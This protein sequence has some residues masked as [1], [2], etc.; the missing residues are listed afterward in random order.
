MTATQDT[1]ATKAVK[2]GWRESQ[3]LSLDRIGW[4]IRSATQQG[5]SH[6]KVMWFDIFFIAEP[7][8]IRELI[9]K[10]PHLLHRDPFTTNVLRRIMG[11][12]V[13]IAED[14]AW[15]RQRK[16]VAPAFHAMRIRA[17]AE[18]MAAYTREMVGRWQDGQTVALDKE[19]TQLTLRI[20]AKTMFNVDLL[21][22]A[23]RIG[24]LMQDLLETGEKQ[25]DAAYP[26]PNWVPT[27]T[28]RRQNAALRELHELIRDIIRQRQA[29]GGDAG[30]LLSMLLAARDDEGRPMSEAQII[31]ECVTLLAA[32]HETTAVALM[33]AW[34]LLAQH[35]DVARRLE[36]EVDD[37]LAGQPVTFERLAELPY[38]ES[39][40]KETLR[41]YPPAFSFGRTPQEDIAFEIEPD[42]NR[43]S[44][45]KS[46]FSSYFFRKGA[47]LI[48][49]TIAMH[50]LPEYYPEP[51][52]FRPERWAAG[53]PQPPKYAYLPFGGG[54]RVCLGNLFAM[55]E[56]QVILAT[57]AQHVRLSPTA[58]GLPG[59]EPLISL[60]PKGPVEMRVRRRER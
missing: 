29:R 24:R 32:G 26:P 35:R 23:E 17:Y 58:E 12:G 13:F 57:M 9:V 33:W 55:M 46:G 59:W 31:D 21:P 34:L 48:I 7:N 20:I 36:A 22:E 52:A 41:L 42:Q 8:V 28:N 10:R 43:V 6:Y 37:A 56:A 47:S 39:I 5:V 38:T 45:E 2:V 60:R 18:T 49:S 53:A 27:A 4:M 50:R 54:P 11:N 15:Q 40:I 14:E 3:A 25:L 44:S 1:L 30:D 51:E 19:L 16:L